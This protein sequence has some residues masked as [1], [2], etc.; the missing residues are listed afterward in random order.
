[1]GD[2]GKLGKSVHGE[3]PIKASKTSSDKATSTKVDADLTCD[4]HTPADTPNKEEDKIYEFWKTYKEEDIIERRKIL[5]KLFSNFE[6][7]DI[8]EDKK[9]DKKMKEHILVSL[10]QSY[11]DDL[12]CYIT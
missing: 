1:M 3:N 8:I 12:V 5:E 10:M 6:I 7:I 4:C 2:K 11:F 9:I